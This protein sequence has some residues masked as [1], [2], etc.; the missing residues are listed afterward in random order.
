MFCDAGDSLSGITFI[1]SGLGGMSGAQAKAA[2]IAG[3]A[4]IVSEINPHAAKKRHEQGWL[5][6]IAD[7]TDDA[8]DR[9][10]QAKKWVEPHPSDILVTS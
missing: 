6:E 2:V 4:C 10:I 3:A 5:S 8:I 9:M 7:S 1:T